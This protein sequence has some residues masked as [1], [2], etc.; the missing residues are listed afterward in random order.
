[1]QDRGTYQ[2]FTFSL[3]AARKFVFLIFRAVFPN[4][5]RSFSSQPSETRCRKFA[6]PLRRTLSGS[7]ELL[8]VSSRFGPKR[9][10]LRI[11]IFASPLEMR[12]D[13][14]GLEAQRLVSRAGP[15]AK[16][17]RMRHR[18]V[19]IMRLTHPLRG[20]EGMMETRVVRDPANL[21]E[22]RRVVPM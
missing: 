15:D 14:R 3:P 21:L 18:I 4:R 10:A 7:F 1:M 9:R 19:K 8:S 13:D 16:V 17:E 5:R 6:V 12:Q 22:R 2:V 20:D 11:D